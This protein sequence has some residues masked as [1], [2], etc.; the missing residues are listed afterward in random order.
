[1]A[2]EPED[3][4]ELEVLEPDE[5]EEQEAET[6]EEAE[7]NAEEEFSIE[8]EGEEAEEE[9]PLIKDLRQQLRDAKREVADFRKAQMP[10][11]EVGEKPTL[12]SCD[13]DADAFEA[14]LDEW[15]DR[16]RQADA[17]EE[18]ATKT[19]EVRN[20]EF[21]RKAIH[22][23][24]RLQALPIPDDQKE[25]A[26]KIVIAALPQIIQSTIIEY[27]DDPAKIVVAL[28]K[29]PQKLQQIAN[30][31]DPI[32]ALLALK[33][34]ERNLKVVTRKRPPAPEAET[35]VRGSAQFARSDKR[36]EQLEKEA[37]RTGDR[38]KLIAYRAS[39]QKAA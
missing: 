33:E 29:H 6:S 34:M 32:R 22:Y 30:E 21:Q 5:G 14:K 13:Y 25:E 36:L 26:E 31:P 35:I 23:K 39:Q 11:I 10:K 1:M 28:A 18:E 15:K 20:H 2:D 3:N 12:E 17:Q 37:L 27:M 4:E 19:A 38:S 9:Q 16:K 8:I 24:A 7:E